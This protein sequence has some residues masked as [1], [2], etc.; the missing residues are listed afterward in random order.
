M[1]P[2][3]T[4]ESFDMII[5]FP[6]AHQVEEETESETEGQSFPGSPRQKR[7][8]S[9]DLDMAM[10]FIDRSL[11][12]YQGYRIPTEGVD[13]MRF[14][15]PNA[16]YLDQGTIFES[17]DTGA[18]YTV[19]ERFYAEDGVTPTGEVLLAGPRTPERWERLIPTPE[20][21]IRFFHAW[22]KQMNAAYKFE[23]DTNLKQVSRPWTDTITWQ[24]VRTQP[25]SLS[26]KPFQGVKETKPRFREYLMEEGANCDYMTHIGGQLFDSVVQ[27]DFWS[28]TNFEAS[29][30]L[31]YF[32]RFF[33]LHR[34]VW[35]W[36]GVKEIL[37]WRQTDDAIV[38]RWRNDI[39][40]RSLQLYFQTE[41]LYSHPVRR[42]RDID[43]CVEVLTRGEHW[44]ET[45]TVVDPTGCVDPTGLVQVNLSDGPGKLFSNPD[46]IDW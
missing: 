45:E 18:F 5:A 42:L 8:G 30:L 33:E 16:F 2:D 24:V 3:G 15:F 1:L 6:F 34:W 39:V 41:R 11:R 37:F 31:N 32:I 23:S 20:N 19:K 7:G 17:M 43:L 36:N 46:F 4:L 26:E 29:Y 25:G 9:A 13:P 22:P 28:K 35:K 40:S 21:R 27:F 14:T 10:D 38:T 44:I 12:Q